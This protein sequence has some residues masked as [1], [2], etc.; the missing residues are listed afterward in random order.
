[1]SIPI[2][3]EGAFTQQLDYPCSMVIHECN[4]R[5]PRKQFN[6]FNIRSTGEGVE[7]QNVLMRQKPT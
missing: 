5:T 4:P 2:L 1:M 7:N 6:N 3:S